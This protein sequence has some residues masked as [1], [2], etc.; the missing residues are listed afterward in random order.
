MS[1]FLDVATFRRITVNIMVL[2]I[3]AHMA[4]YSISLKATI[5][6]VVSMSRVAGKKHV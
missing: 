5:L 6:K 1:Y 2:G 3:P 4:K